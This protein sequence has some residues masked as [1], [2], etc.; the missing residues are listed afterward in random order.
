MLH[1]PAHLKSIPLSDYI[2]FGKDLPGLKNKVQEKHIKLYLMMLDS[3]FKRDAEKSFSNYFNLLSI[4]ETLPEQAIGIEVEVEGIHHNFKEFAPTGFWT[5]GH[6]GSL[7]NNG[8]EFISKPAYPR[9]CRIALAL[10]W[11]FFNVCTKDSYSF[12]WRTSIH[13]HVNQREKT[14]KEILKTLILYLIFEEA[15]FDYAGIDRKQGNFC[16]PLHEC[17]L[18]PLSSAKCIKGS[19][20][21]ALLEG[22]GKYSA[23]NLLPLSELGTLEWRHLAGTKDLS[24][25]GYWISMI[26][27]LDAYATTVTEE[28]LLTVLFELN[29]ESY[30]DMFSRDVFGREL[31]HILNVPGIEKSLSRGISIAKLWMQEGNTF[32]DF[33]GT[34]RSVETLKY[35]TESGKI[36]NAPIK[37]PLD[38]TKFVKK[39]SVFHQGN[40]FEV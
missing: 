13:I 37:A 39:G 6:D 11:T 34:Q 36:K 19:S 17:G 15:L 30:Y 9:N 38:A 8:V 14:E 31:A 1:F 7:K 12:E 28:K 22:W 35:F 21:F 33:S 2:H 32:S 16:V 3:N 40:I 10:L 4:L 23:L 25:I 26:L 18:L 20:L 5:W 27:R 24:R 29:S